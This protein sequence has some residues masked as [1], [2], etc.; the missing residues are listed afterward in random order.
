[1]ASAYHPMAWSQNTAYD[2]KG[3]GSAKN[4][5]NAVDVLDLVIFNFLV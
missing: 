5:K 2:H 4:Q 3:I 1:M